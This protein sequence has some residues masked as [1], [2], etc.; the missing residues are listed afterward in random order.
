MVKDMVMQNSEP[1]Q[2]RPV[3]EFLAFPKETWSL[4]TGKNK[5]DYVVNLQFS[6]SI[7]LSAAS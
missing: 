3:P 6:D 5:R 2:S 1:K 7:L 4:S